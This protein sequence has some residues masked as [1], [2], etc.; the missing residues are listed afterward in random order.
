MRRNPPRIAELG[1]K[2]EEA[3]KGRN[4]AL[5][6]RHDKSIER[7]NR[8]GRL[9]CSRCGFFKPPDSFYMDSKK[10]TEIR[11]MCKFCWSESYKQYIGFTLRGVMVRILHS[12]RNRAQGNSMKPSR[13]QA[14][15][16]ELDLNFLL[17]LWLKQKG[18]CAYSDLIMNTT[19]F[20]SCRLS[21]E[22]LDNALGYVPHNVVFIC[23]EFNTSDFSVHAS[24]RVLGTP[25]WSQDKVESLPRLISRTAPMNSHEID[26][27]TRIEDTPRKKKAANRKP[28]TNGDLL[29]TACDTFKPIDDFRFQRGGVSGRHS[30]CK[31]CVDLKCSRYYCS[32]G[33]FFSSRLSYAK[34]K[35]KRR[36]AK[37]RK[38]ASDFDLNL[39]HMKDIFRQQS[40]LCFYSGIKLSIR[41]LSE[42][43]CSIERLDNSKGYVLNNVVLICYEF[44]TSDYTY[45]ANGPVGGSCQWSK[46]KFAFLI[47]WLTYKITPI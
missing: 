13:E 7:A 29:C 37:G 26:V 38:E 41:P 47:H 44:Q 28:A 8:E 31:E 21:L 2:V 5:T 10:K 36:G 9:L 42:W 27:L 25:K 33:G 6:R 43:M 40:G 39:Q 12:A 46:D 34:T 32:F 14:G 16:F 45:A 19:P 23:S 4:Y 3:R 17:D 22:R 1:K 15:Q 11:S 35:A 18:R 24:K 30:F 20:T